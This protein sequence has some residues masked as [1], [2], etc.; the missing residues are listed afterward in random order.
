MKKLWLVLATTTLISS[1]SLADDWVRGYTRRDG[2]Y[3]QP[4][5]RSERDGNPRDNWSTRG[6]FNPHTG[7]AGTRDPYQSPSYLSPSYGDRDRS[8]FGS[9]RR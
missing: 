8:L 9:P 1:P 3:V 4:H 6:N 2:T 7:E 5:Y